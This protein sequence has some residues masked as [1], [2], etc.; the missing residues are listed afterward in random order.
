MPKRH[1]TRHLQNNRN[2]G[3]AIP[4]TN[5]IAARGKSGTIGKPAR[6]GNMPY[7]FPI[8][9]PLLLKSLDTAMNYLEQTG[10]ANPLSQTRGFCAQVIY[11]EWKVGRRHSVWF[12][13]KAITALEQARKENWARLLQ[14]PM[15]ASGTEG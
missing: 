5:E 11:E 10:Q 8:P 3:K 1:F 9:I 15:T 2:V 7:D 6:C 12:A 14:D 4:Q 13:N